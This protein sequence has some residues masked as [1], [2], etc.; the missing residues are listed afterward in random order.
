MTASLGKFCITRAAG[1]RACSACSSTSPAELQM[2]SHHSASVWTA[3][4]RRSTSVTL[5]RGIKYHQST[6]WERY[7]LLNSLI[8]QRKRPSGTSMSWARPTRWVILLWNTAQGSYSELSADN[9]VHLELYNGILFLSY[10]IM[11]KFHVEQLTRVS[12]DVFK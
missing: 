9:W 12:Q 4:D 6:Q 2:H 8:N 5:E 11:D 7:S 3:W 10:D 1:G